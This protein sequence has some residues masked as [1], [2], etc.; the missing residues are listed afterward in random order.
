[1]KALG[2]IIGIAAVIGIILGIDWCFWKLYLYMMGETWPDGPA[3]LVRPG[4]WLF[5]CWLFMLS[6][7]GRLL[8]GSRKE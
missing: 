7:A 8:F 3:T 4:F 2:W 5:V 6:L 1:M